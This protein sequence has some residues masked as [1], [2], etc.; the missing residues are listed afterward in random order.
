MTEQLT[1]FEMG[2]ELGRRPCSQWPW[3]LAQTM[4]KC[5]DSGLSGAGSAN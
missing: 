1:P 5:R 4:D 3:A 2:V